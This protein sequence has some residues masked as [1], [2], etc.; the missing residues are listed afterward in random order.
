MD[1]GEARSGFKKMKYGGFEERRT[2]PCDFGSVFQSK[3]DL[4]K[5]ISSTLDLAAKSNHLPFNDAPSCNVSTQICGKPRNFD[6]D[7]NSQVVSI[8]FNHEPFNLFKKYEHEQPQD[9]LSE[10]GSTCAPMSEKDSMRIWKEIKQNGF[11]SSSH[12]GASVPPMPKPRGRKKGNE[13]IIKK[14]IEIA[15]REQV[16]RFAK[17]A[18]PSGL[19]NELNP[20]IINHVRNRKQVHSIIENLVRSARNKNKKGEIKQD[21][22]NLNHSSES[23]QTHICWSKDNDV[24]ELKLSS[25]STM[26]S[27]NM[28]SLSNDESANI[29]TVDLLSVKAASVAAQWLELLHQDIK[30]R[31]AALRRS[32]KRVQTVTQTEL[33]LLISREL[34]SNQENNPCVNITNK[35]FHKF[36]WTALFDQMDKSLSEEEKHLENSLN[37]VREMLLHCEHGLLHF[38]LANA[39]QHH[40]TLQSS[41]MF[42]KIEPILDKDLAVRAAAAAIYSTSNFLQPAENLP[43]C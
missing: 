37:Q 2:N 28:S 30:G 10:C 29:S 6:I 27:E 22:V 20:G 17:V 42:P 8:S 43:C 1:G 5:N 21:D 24:L 13:S 25:A 3:G 7:L 14:K 34:S 26:A 16:D 39:L 38:P 31:L 40:A 35:E 23:Q 4:T 12:G 19:L 36:R 11:L 9:T 41:Y 33:P 15:K 32:K 18:A